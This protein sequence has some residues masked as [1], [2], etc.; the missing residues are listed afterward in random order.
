PWPT[1]PGQRS[2]TPASPPPPTPPTQT[3]TPQT[4][5]PTT[6]PRTR[7]WQV[8]LP[9]TPRRR[10]RGRVLVLPVWP[11]TPRMVRTALML[12]RVLMLPRTAR[13][14]ARVVRTYPPRQTRHT[15]QPQRLQ[16]TRPARPILVPAVRRTWTRA[17]PQPPT[18][19][20]VRIAETRGARVRQ[21][22]LLVHHHPHRRPRRH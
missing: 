12:A 19:I 21:V 20:G 16:P 10:T 15:H 18:R 13:R 3:R 14:P 6:P 22:P 11:A 9:R 5:P 4:P 8:T 1:W 17:V 2:P 7:I